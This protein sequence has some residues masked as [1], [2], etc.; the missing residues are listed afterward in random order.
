MS[1]FAAG[2][3][4]CGA[5]LEAARRAQGERRRIALPALPAVPQELLIL[6]GLSIVTLFAPFFGVVF[7]LLVIR[8]ES[9]TG[10]V[11]LRR[12]LWVVV[13]VGIVLLV[14]PETRYAGA[15]TFL[16]G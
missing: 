13:A 1:Q 3:A 16:Y 8:R 5:D 4:I 15:L 11:A 6:L 14:L 7:S 10:E 2:C 12:A 9:G